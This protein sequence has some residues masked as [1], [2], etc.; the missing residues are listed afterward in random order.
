MSHMYECRTS[1]AYELMWMNGNCTGTMHY[2]QAVDEDDFHVICEGIPCNVAVV[3][4]YHQDGWNCI[5]I[6]YT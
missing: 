6:N 4:F 1:G 3:E 5:K 2:E